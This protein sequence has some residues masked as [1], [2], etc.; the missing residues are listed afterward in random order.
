MSLITRFSLDANRLTIVFI[1]SVII[2]G[3]IQFFDFP[4]QEDP[5]IVIR[6]VVVTAFFPGM[7]AA[8]MEDL[9]T[10][11]LEAELRT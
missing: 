4:R 7:E 5:P 10:R 9:V 2:L 11:R 3:L 8:D 1:A 6:E